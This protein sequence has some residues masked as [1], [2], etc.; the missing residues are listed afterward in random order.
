L[1]VSRNSTVIKVEEVQVEELHS[2]LS[3]TL[4]PTF[5]ARR[6]GKK[7]GSR[8]TLDRVSMRADQ[9]HRI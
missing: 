4:A 2:Y 1:K 3:A 5:I 8:V 7:H 6:A 9:R